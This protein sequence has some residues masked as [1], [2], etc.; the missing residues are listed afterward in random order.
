MIVGERKEKPSDIDTVIITTQSFIKLK[1]QNKYPI[2]K[3]NDL[4]SEMEILHIPELSFKKEEISLDD[5]DYPIPKAFVLGIQTMR[6]KEKSK[7]LIKMK[8]IFKYFDKRIDK[9]TNSPSAKI[10]YNEEFR[11]EYKNEK[12]IC[13]I[14]L[15]DFFICQ[16]LMDRGEIRKKILKNGRH[17]KYARNPDVAKFN[18]RCIYKNQTIYEKQGVVSELDKDFLFEIEKRIVQNIKIGEQSEIRVK[19]S[20]MKDKNKEF[21]TFYNIDNEEDTFFLAELIDLEIFDY[22]FKPDK[23]KI[24]KKKVLYKGIG[25]E[26]PDRESIVKLKIQIKIGGKILYNN[27]E[28]ENVVESYLK[29]DTFTKTYPLWRTKINEEYKINEIGEE[30][31]YQRDEEIFT[32][33]EKECNTDNIIKTCDLRLYSIPLIVRKVLIHMKRN[34]IIFIKTNFLDYFEADSF[35]LNNLGDQK[36]TNANIEI[37]L[38]LYEFVNRRLFSKMSYEEKLQELSKMKEIAND[39]FKEGKIFRSGKIYQNIN[40][41]FNYGDVFKSGDEKSEGSL[42]KNQPE[43]YKK[44][45]ELRLSTHNNYAAVKFKLSKYFSCYDISKKVITEFDPFNPKANFLFG[46]SC[47]HLKFYDEAIKSLKSICDKGNDN[48]EFVNLLNE[49]EHLRNEE[50]KKQKN[51]YKKMIFSS[52]DD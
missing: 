32:R 12:L 2:G 22:I 14:E 42:N 9:Y 30:V 39:F 41:R 16:N 35:V 25:K 19:P 52:L 45:M 13:E 11:N 17:W 24:S 50:L 5:S 49:A 21:L 46:K 34:E 37:Y 47:I 4:E 33:F 38:H 36:S 20:Y 40:S 29:N 23:D 6:K 10:L 1:I 26:C 8:Y 3:I 51:I 48:K 15:H 7:L 43:I 31:D 27:F 18:L 28:E 44:F